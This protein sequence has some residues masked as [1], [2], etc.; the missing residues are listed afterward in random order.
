MGYKVH[1]RNSICI[2]LQHFYS[3]LNKEVYFY[4]T[5]V[6]DHVSIQIMNNAFDAL[7]SL[8]SGL[9]LVVN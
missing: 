2:W 6:L 7:M 9:Q 8:A 5:A 1:Y 4:G 3:P